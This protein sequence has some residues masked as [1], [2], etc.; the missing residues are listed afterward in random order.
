M[1]AK[2]L[3]VRA[4]MRTH[5]CTHMGTHVHTHGHMRVH[6]CTH[7]CAQTCMHAHTHTRT[8]TPHYYSAMKNNE[9]IPFATTWMDLESVILSKVSQTDMEKYHVT[10]LTRGI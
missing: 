4:R 8:H 5:M 7:T 1:T 3:H 9:T 6:T 2:V 10:S